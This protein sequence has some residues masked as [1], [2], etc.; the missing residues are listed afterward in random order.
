MR[1]S[2]TA[3]TR[4]MTRDANTATNPHPMDGQQTTKINNESVI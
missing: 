4:Q 2:L 3:R 1:P